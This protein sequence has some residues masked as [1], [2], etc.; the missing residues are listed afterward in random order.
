MVKLDDIAAKDL[1]REPF[2]RAV[3]I[4]FRRIFYEA[5]IDTV[6]CQLHKVKK[7]SATGLPFSIPRFIDITEYNKT[8]SHAAKVL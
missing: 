3:G 5:V 6:R 2:D 8:S 7:L 4:T 1:T